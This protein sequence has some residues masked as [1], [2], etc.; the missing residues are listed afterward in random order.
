MVAAE[1]K[2]L[3]ENTLSA[4]TAIIVSADDVHFNATVISPD[5]SE[6]TRL[7]KQQLVYAA[8]GDNINNGAIHAISIRT[9]T[10]VEWQIECER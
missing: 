9:F 7:Q 10:P 3:L 1:I 6:K 8:L 2:Q 5:F 4:C